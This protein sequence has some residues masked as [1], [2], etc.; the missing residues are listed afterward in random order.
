MIKYPPPLLLVDLIVFYPSFPL[1]LYIVEVSVR[2][3]SP[4]GVLY[5]GEAGGGTILGPSARNQ[6]QATLAQETKPYHY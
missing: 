4:R 2:G 6:G 5:P 3:P 1:C